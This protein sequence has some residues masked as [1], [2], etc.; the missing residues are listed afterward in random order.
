[1]VAARAMSHAVECLR[2][3]FP[4]GGYEKKAKAV[5]GT[6]AGDLHDIG[7][8]IVKMLLE[9][10][11]Y[12]VVDLGTDVA[13]E[14]FVEAIRKDSPRYVLMSTLITLTMESMNRTVQAI[15][16]AKGGA[17]RT[18]NAIRAVLR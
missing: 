14:A 10:S 13:P 9:G 1:M 16:A 17:L 11:G 7:K 4:Q 2:P 3:A 5:L 8:N 15:E 18:S 6:V 12:E